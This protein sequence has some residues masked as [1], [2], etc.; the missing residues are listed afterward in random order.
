[1]PVD[2]YLKFGSSFG[3]G[4]EK[5]YGLTLGGVVGRMLPGS[6]VSVSPC[7]AWK[8]IAKT[9]TDCVPHFLVAMA[10]DLQEYPKFIAAAKAF[11]L[12]PKGAV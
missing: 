6:S 5:S 8:I 4:A 10:P 9:S 11:P 2:P 12:R 1:M 3:Y 7:A